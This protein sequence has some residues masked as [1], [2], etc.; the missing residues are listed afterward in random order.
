MRLRP[1]VVVLGLVVAGCAGGGNAAAPPLTTGSDPI[2][3]APAPPAAAGV[4]FPVAAV[5]RPIVLVGPQRETVERAE[6]EKVKALEA[7][8]AGEFRFTGVEPPS[9]G[10]T[11]VVLPGGPA[12]LP[13]IGVGDAVAAMSAGGRGGV[14]LE[15]VGA[16]LGTA[17]FHTDRGPVELPAWRFRSVFG[18]VFAWP[19]ITPEAFWKPGEV[20]LSN[21]SATTS[22][23]VELQVELGAPFPPCPGGKPVFKEPVA[24]EGE[25]SVK[26]TVRMTGGPL[27]D[28]AHRLVYR[29][30]SYTVKLTE[31]LGARLLVDENNGVMPVVTR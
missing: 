9:P 2:S 4:D 14:P 12:T 25:T 13:L 29:P 30:Q 28:C 17:S 26:I 21:H 5:P 15:L 3:T 7:G 8:F 20:P 24:I 22:D 11:S 27:G 16:E 1:L 18:S 31:P 10:S 23:G 6:G 19:A